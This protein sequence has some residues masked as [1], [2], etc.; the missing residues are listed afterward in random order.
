VKKFAGMLRLPTPAPINVSCDA[1]LTMVTGL[2]ALYNPTN[3]G[4]T[5][6]SKPAPS[7]PMT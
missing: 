7:V 1:V 2:V 5:K 6:E 4:D 3:G